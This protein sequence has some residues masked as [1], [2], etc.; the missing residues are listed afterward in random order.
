MSFK[1][2]GLAVAAF[3]CLAGSA[4]A[5]IESDSMGDI[6]AWGQR[7]LA[8]G[9][10]E[11]PTG[12]WSGSD[13][14][15]LLELLKSVRTI[16]LSPAERRLLRRV[17]LSPATQPR[18]EYA[19]DLLAERARLMLELGEARAA[20]SLVPQLQQTARGLDAETLAIDLDMA[21]GQEASACR[22]LNAQPREGDYWLKLRAV[23]AV[24]QENYSGAEL[25]IEVAAAQ[26]VRD[27]W[28]V[29]AIFAAAGDV[30]N[31]PNARFDNGL[32]I[33]LSS[34]AALDT[35]RVTLSASRPDLAAAAAKRPG[36]PP[37]LRARF[38]QIAGEIDLISAEDRR[39]ILL[40]RL[41][42]ED[43]SASSSIEQALETLTDPE[44]PAGVKADRLHSIL[45]TGSRADF[46]RYSS[47]A[48]LF[49]SDLRRLPRNPETAPHALSFARAALGAGDGA[50][51]RQWLSAF[52]YEGVAQPDPFALAVVEA[53]DIISGGD[54]SPASLRAV[55]GRLIEAATSSAQEDQV[56]AI[57]T[58]WSGL[59]LALSPDSR[60]L[61]SQTSD[62]GE[63]IAQGHLTA[64]QA[65]ARGGATGEAALLILGETYGD[66]N[67]LSR[68]DLSVL[69]ET[70]VSM[71]ARD[72]ASDL[73]MEASGFW[74]D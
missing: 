57:L 66:A 8:A 11:F 60:A 63:R 43:Y 48:K 3:G 65:A 34:K 32:N 29:E 42:E 71:D 33:A 53:A 40:D 16:Q 13:N 22:Q 25:A 20:A 18:G 74:K 67:R 64:L 61:I 4:A 72:I 14:E 24:L 10:K 51:A 44:I 1:A 9:E 73:A 23:C 55:E 68:Y 28:M 30:P 54:A 46:I 70:L 69:L 49:L 52:D 37:E 39:Q 19:E 36:V 6:S 47:T 50:L 56:A 59:G 21:S 7:Y 26:G 31:P 15:T 12:L 38:A 5:Q 27:P 17:V 62:R 41:A 2:F 58:T 35:S 45:A